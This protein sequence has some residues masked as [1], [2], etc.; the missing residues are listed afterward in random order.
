MGHKLRHKPLTS[1]HKLGKRRLSRGNLFPTYVTHR[2]V[3]PPDQALHVTGAAL[4]VMSACTLSM[5][6]TMFFA[7]IKRSSLT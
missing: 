6:N 3:L 2:L 7:K 5:Q 1:I 4:V